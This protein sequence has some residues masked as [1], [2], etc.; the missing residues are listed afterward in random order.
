MTTCDIPRG[1]RRMVHVLTGKHMNRAISQRSP[2]RR[3]R[4][5]EAKGDVNARFLEVKNIL[6]LLS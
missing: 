3:V 5:G 4:H 2:F 1:S 6:A